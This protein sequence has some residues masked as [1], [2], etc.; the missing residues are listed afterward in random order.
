MGQYVWQTYEEVYNTAIKIGSSIRGRGVN[1]VSS[2]VSFPFVG[3]VVT[4]IAYQ[5]FPFILFNQ[6]D[7]CGIYGVN[8]P[9]WVTAMQVKPI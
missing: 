1:P 8:C 4:E 6:G 2:Y 5:L 9:E 7:R 3:Y